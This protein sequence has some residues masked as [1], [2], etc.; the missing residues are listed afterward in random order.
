M[1]LDWEEASQTT[2]G[3]LTWLTELVLTDHGRDL[4]GSMLSE[5][6]RLTNL[7]RLNLED[8]DFDGMIPTELGKL[9]KLTEL[10]LEDNDDIQGTIPSELGNSLSYSNLIWKAT[11]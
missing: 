9:T 6:G 3:V 8:N 2:I 11:T 5:F 1:D 4:G 10:D 7:V